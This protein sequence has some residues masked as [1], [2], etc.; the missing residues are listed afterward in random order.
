MEVVDGVKNKKILSAK[1]YARLYILFVNI[2]NRM[3]LNLDSL[4]KVQ[5]NTF[6]KL[7][8]KEQWYSIGENNELDTLPVAKSNDK[9]SS[10]IDQK[11][12][13]KVIFENKY[14]TEKSEGNIEKIYTIEKYVLWQVVQNFHKL[15]KDGDLEW[16]QMIEIPQKED[17]ID[18]QN[19]LKYLEDL[20]S[21]TEPFFELYCKK[22]FPLAILA[23]SEGGLIPAIGSIQNENRG[24]V[25][26][27]VGT[28]EELEKQKK[29]AKK[30]LMRN[31]S[32][33]LMAHLRSCYRKWGCLKKSMYIC[34]I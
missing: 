6:V 32:F 3:D 31:C 1:E 11:L 30:Q 25:H 34:R 26:F 22:N 9:Y 4:D 15:A 18:P 2:G 27:S 10:F 13:G 16:A 5:E 14:S 23:V 28:N 20:N 29:L 33:T 8:N 21:R 7:S 17:S 24:F 12:G 19:L